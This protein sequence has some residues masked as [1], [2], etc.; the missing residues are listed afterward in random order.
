MFAFF[1]YTFGT[2]FLNFVIYLYFFKLIHY[3]QLYLVLLSF[4]L[5]RKLSKNAYT[6]LNP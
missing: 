3:P 2:L 5:C 6:Y 4:D 1:L